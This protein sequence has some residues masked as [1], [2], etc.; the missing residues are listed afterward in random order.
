MNRNNL[1]AYTQVF[2]D[3]YSVALKYTLHKHIALTNQGQHSACKGQYCSAC[4]PLLIEMSIAPTILELDF[5][6]NRRAG[7]C[8][9]SFFTMKNLVFFLK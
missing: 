2:L 6:K 5:L 7:F 9:Q 1:A 3:K 8:G 4:L